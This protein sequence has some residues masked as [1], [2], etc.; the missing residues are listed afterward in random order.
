MV[1]SSK[2]A[3]VLMH[4]VHPCHGSLLSS[5]VHNALALVNIVRVHAS[6]IL[7]KPGSTTHFPTST[8]SAGLQCL[9]V[10]ARV[11]LVRFRAVS[12]CV[13]LLPL[14]NIF[15]PSHMYRYVI[16]MGLWSK[17]DVNGHYFIFTVQILVNP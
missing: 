15:R 7:A 9:S 4:L 3:W 17:Y 1:R 12:H 13:W 11:H 6:S 16:T 8:A 10:G 14:V 5:T 2:H